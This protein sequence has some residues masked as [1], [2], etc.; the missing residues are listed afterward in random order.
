MKRG[1]LLSPKRSDG[2][3]STKWADMKSPGG[4]HDYQRPVVSPANSET[5]RARLSLK[6]PL[7][8]KHFDSPKHCLSVW[9]GKRH[10]DVSPPTNICFKTWENGGL[11]HLKMFTSIFRCPV[12]GEMFLSGSYG[13]CETLEEETYC[14]KI[15]VRVNWYK[16]KK[17][18]EHA[19]AA[20]ALDCFSFRETECYNYCKEEPY[21]KDESS[22]R[23][24]IPISVGTE[25]PFYDDIMVEVSNEE[26]QGNLPREE[27]LNEGSNDIEMFRAE[28]NAHLGIHPQF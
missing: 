23:V 2:N 15:I 7:L 8:H 26:D 28:R 25:K 9:Y 5:P 18:A 6:G 22:A 10:K 27:D 3:T 11:P 14:S 12:S 20:R 21:L 24:R 16:Q 19:A 4:W 1:F 17:S 13:F